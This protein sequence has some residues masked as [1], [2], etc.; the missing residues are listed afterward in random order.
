VTSQS[1]LASPL[2]KSRNQREGRDCRDRAKA[3]A[4]Q[5]KHR[6]E[7]PR[8]RRR[9]EEIDENRPAQIIESKPN[10]TNNLHI[11]QKGYIVRHAV[12]P[13]HFTGE[14]MTKFV[15]MFRK[16]AIAGGSCAW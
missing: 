1:D 10:P 3:N 2:G 15:K 6:R 11:P 4:P 14:E 9:R 16:A 8:Q 12:S 7:S 5:R 13:T